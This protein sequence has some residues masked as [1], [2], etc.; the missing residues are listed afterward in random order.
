MH[1]VPKCNREVTNNEQNKLIYNICTYLGSGNSPPPAIVALMRESNS[2][3]PRMASC[4]WRGV[5]RFTLRSLEAFP[6]NSST[7][8]SIRNTHTV[9]LPDH[10]A[11]AEQ[12]G[13]QGNGIGSGMLAKTGAIAYFSSE[14]LEDS[15]TVHS[16]CGSYTTMAGCAGLQVPVDTSHWK[17]TRQSQEHQ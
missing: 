15:R 11:C 2:S 5:I 4:K 8:K 16:C 1:L 12:V 14:V 6:A 7:C 9:Q 13:A 17:L 10:S 3:S